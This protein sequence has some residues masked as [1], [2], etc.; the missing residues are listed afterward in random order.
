M[1]TKS[2]YAE[3]ATLNHLLSGTLYI[4]LIT[5]GDDSGVTEPTSDSAYARQ[6]GTFTVTGSSAG[7]DAEVVFPYATQD[8]GQVDC[9]VFDALTGGNLLYILSV[10]NGPFTY[11]TDERIR[12]PAGDA[13]ITES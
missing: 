8:N 10:D 9:A 3:N 2:D 5:A 6:S 1:G 4:G 12:I 13:T 11:D 7:N